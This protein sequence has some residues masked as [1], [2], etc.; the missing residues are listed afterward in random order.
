MRPILWP[1]AAL[2]LG[3]LVT[4]AAAQEPGADFL[5]VRR[6]EALPAPLSAALEGL[7]TARIIQHLAFLTD[8]RRQGRGLGTEGLDATARY[9][10]GQLKTIGIP[11]LGPSYIQPVPLRE[12]RP[13]R[14]QIRLSAGSVTCIFE[15]GRNAVLPQVEPGHLSGSAVFAG[16]GIQEPALHH[17]DF[18]GLDVRGKVVV[19]LDGLPDGTRWQT[20]ELRERYASARPADRYDTRLAL[21]EKLG[22][23]AA[24]ALEEGLGARIAAGKESALPYFLAARGVP[25]A[26]E[27][28][29]ARVALTE[30]LRTLVFSGRVGEADLHIRGHVRELLSD[31]VIGVLKGSD[32]Q[33]NREAIL[34]GAHMDHLGMPNGILHPG[35]DDNASGVSALLEIARVLAESPVRPRRTLLF[36]FWTGEEEGKFGS[37]HYTR[38]PRWP[39]AAT[40]AYLN[41]DMIGHPW[42]QA[43]LGALLAASGVKDPKAFLEG[44]DPAA[45]AEPGLPPGHRELA[46]LL[47]QAGRGTGMSL[48]LDWTD[49]RHG[50]SDYRD[51]ARLGLPFLRFFGSYFPEYH[52]P[53]DTLDKLD[54]DQVKRMTRLV[55][56]TAWLLAD[57]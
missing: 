18:R 10:A 3:C 8:P 12:V 24:I 4:F 27:P 52:R 57:R 51:F 55:L 50:G 23:K 47:L 56:A 2:L 15:A 33:L 14:G 6:A 17:D 41:L 34:I 21:L 45:F 37:G 7:D 13:G 28:P 40:R 31:N 30:D 26:G 42:T 43:D 22:A 49:G 16:Y 1:G 5:R 20:P 36:A 54:P 19:F 32:P 25:R 46:P 48:H 38:H 11:A 9:L 29:L 53:G 35:A 39:L 44:L